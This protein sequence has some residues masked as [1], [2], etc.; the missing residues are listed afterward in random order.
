MC[1]SA[2]RAEIN[3]VILENSGIHLAKYKTPNI[4]AAEGLLIFLCCL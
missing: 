3:I 4:F 1:F 2:D